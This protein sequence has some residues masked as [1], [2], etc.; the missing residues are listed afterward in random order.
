[1]VGGRALPAGVIGVLL[2]SE[3]IGAKS[4]VGTAQEAFEHGM[5]AGWSV[6]AASVGFLLLAFGFAGKIQASAQHTI[7]GLVEQRFGPGARIVVSI[8]MIYALL[9]V[10]VGNYVSGAAALSQSL[11]INLT[12]STALIAL[13]STVYYVF[14]GLKGIAYV[15][16]LHS[17]VKLTGIAIL[18]AFAAFLTGGIAPIQQALPASFFTWNGQVGGPTILAWVVG[19]VGAIFSTQFIIQAIAA[20]RSATAARG[21]ALTAALLCLPLG[22]A[23][24][25]VGVA[26]RFLYPHQPSLFALPVFISKMPPVLAA[27]V[28]VSLV[29]S[30][31]VSVSTVALATTALVMRDFYA[32]WRKP[33]PDQEL[34]ATRYI[35]L[36]VGLAPLLFV[37]LTPHILALSFFTRALRLSI[38]LVALM[39]VYL[40]WIRSGRGAVAALVCSGVATTAWY[41]LGNPFGIDNMYVAAVIPPVVLV[42]ERL[43]SKPTRLADAPA[44]ETPA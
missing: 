34:K 40:P 10:N 27:T 28:T 44:K 42:L 31:L 15:T 19:T 30:V 5:A 23:L 13:F 9:L 25:F 43:I 35:A 20:S 6:L 32:P 29:A 17:L 39:G 1:M 38:A 21:A 26:A 4:T 24:G 3:F 36:A 14:G 12:W 22:F 37:V 18:V 8:L 11:H 16:V 2:M 41:L 33:N 7:S